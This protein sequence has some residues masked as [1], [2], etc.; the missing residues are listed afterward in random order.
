MTATFAELGAS[1]TRG[2]APVVVVSGDTHIGPRLVEDLRPYCP[3]EYLDE[4]D[5][6]AAEKDTLV[7]L[8]NEKMFGGARERNGALHP[9]APDMI[10]QLVKNSQTTGHYDM[11]QRLRDYD[12]DGVAAAVILH[13]SQN[14]EPI[15]FRTSP[16]ESAEVGDDPRLSA[17]GYH[18]YNAWLADQITIQPERHVALAY[19][20]LWDIDAAV[21]EMT[22][23]R[24]HGL[25]A[26]NFPAPISG[27]PEYN[28]PIWEPFWAAA[29]D[30]DMPLIGHG[31]QDGTWRYTGVEGPAV[32]MIEGGGW[33]ARRHLHWLAYGGVFYRH[34]R[35][36]VV[37]TEISGDWWEQQM[38][39]MDSVYKGP[40]AYS[41]RQRVPEL[42]SESC[43]RS[44][45]GAWWLCPHETRHA[46]EGGFSGN[47]I[48]GSD[49]P[50]LEGTWRWPEPGDTEPQTHLHQRFAFGGL[51]ERD[52]LMMAGENAVRAYGLD[53]A[54]LQTVAARI[55]TQTLD[56]IRTPLSGDEIP[57]DKNDDM[58]YPFRKNW[59]WS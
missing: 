58:P 6:F 16:F 54:A 41:L 3:K 50:H 20:P 48:W 1:E 43:R 35:L 11:H 10:N 22:W 53:M 57:A 55:N 45:F 49:Y 39:E 44:V 32:Q 23:A 52:V 21:K 27:I 14:G 34:P 4:F 17:V 56:Q 30:L 37:I 33:M 19:V 40:A 51:P 9:G 28:R 12:A 38:L 29:E 5:R 31:G 13:G 7:G 42:P 26:V 59:S 25:K 18:I 8:G 46:V 24:E 47:L 15:P 2:D 36:K